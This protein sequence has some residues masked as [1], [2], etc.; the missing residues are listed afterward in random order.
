EIPIPSKN[1]GIF[2]LPFGFTPLTEVRRARRYT[3]L[4]SRNG[5]IP[6]LLRVT[7]SRDQVGGRLLSY[8]WYRF[9]YVKTNPQF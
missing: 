3:V 9:S 1:A 6:R 4:H 5:S 2:C 8:A 7:R